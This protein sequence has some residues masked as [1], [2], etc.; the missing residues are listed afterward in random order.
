VCPAQPF[1][2]QQVGAGQFDPNPGPARCHIVP[3][4]GVTGDVSAYPSAQAGEAQP[5][6]SGLASS[7]SHAAREYVCLAGPAVN[8]SHILPRGE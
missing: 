6:P 2:V 4:P 8:R 3:A 5:G 1:P 7:A